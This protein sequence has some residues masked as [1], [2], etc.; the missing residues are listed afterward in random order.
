MREVPGERER[1]AEVE[2]HGKAERGAIEQP[3]HFEQRSR[4]FQQTFGGSRHNGEQNER[5]RVQQQ[6]RSARAQKTGMDVKGEAEMEKNGGCEQVGGEIT[7]IDEFVEGV[8]LA[9]V[10]ETAGDER[11]ETEQDE[12]ERFGG[13][14][15][16]VIDEQANCQIEEANRVLVIERGIA[17]ALF[18]KNMV[19]LEVDAIPAE[20]VGGLSKR[21]DLPERFRNVEGIVDRK[22]ADPEELVAEVDIGLIAR[23]ARR[24]I[25]S[26]DP[27]VSSR[28]FAIDP[29]DAIVL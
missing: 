24:D 7:P 23:T 5:R 12:V 14:G 25:N 16:A 27:V 13:A 10:V 22:T 18:D 19:L 1:T 20:R 17:R 11:H 6:P 28:T 15:S 21:R 8:Q 9:R 3:A 4:K 2:Q 29:G 26:D